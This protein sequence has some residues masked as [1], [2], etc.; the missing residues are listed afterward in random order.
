MA[1]QEKAPY[2][3][4]TYEDRD[5]RSK[6][7][8]VRVLQLVERDRHDVEHDR[9]QAETVVH[10]T[11]PNAVGRKILIKARTLDTHYKKVS[12]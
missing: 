4:E 8:R 10:P 11:N 3:G 7:R 5:T 1:D 2:I 9:Y 6:G 12:H